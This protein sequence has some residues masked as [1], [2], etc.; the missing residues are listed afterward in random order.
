[1][2][3]GPQEEHPV[4]LTSVP[5]LHSLKY[6]FSKDRKLEDRESGSVKS[7]GNV[8]AANMSPHMCARM[9][10]S[11]NTKTVC[12]NFLFEFSNPQPGLMQS[13]RPLTTQH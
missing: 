6:H 4:I 2:S 9:M 1:M 7:E 13:D 5:F 11:V 8:R 10:S 3:A 12:T